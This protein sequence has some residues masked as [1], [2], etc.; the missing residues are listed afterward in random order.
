M[1][2]VE[3][4]S[5]ESQASQLIAAVLRRKETTAP[6]TFEPAVAHPVEDV[7]PLF[8][9]SSSDSSSRHSI[10][11]YHLHSLA[12]SEPQSRYGSEDQPDGEESQKENAPVSREI[13]RSD[14]SHPVAPTSTFARPPGDLAASEMR[15]PTRHRFTATNHATKEISPRIPPNIDS[16][17]GATPVKVLS[18]KS[19]VVP[20]RGMPH[21]SINVA[22]VHT[23]HSRSVPRTQEQRSPSPA[24]QDSLVIPWQDP[25]P[26]FL[27]TTEVLAI[28]SS[29]QGESSV[30]QIG[31]S[32]RTLAISVSSLHS[33]L[34]PP[35]AG[36]PDHG[37]VLVAATPSNSDSSQGIPQGQATSLSD[38]QIHDS[39]EEDHG[40]I[41]TAPPSPRDVS[42]ELSSSYRRLLDLDLF[43]PNPEPLIATQATSQFTT[44][45]TQL[46]TQAT[47]SINQPG[48]IGSLRSTDPE[49]DIPLAFSVP[50]TTTTRTAIPR[51]MLGLVHPNKLWRF[52]G[53]RESE[54]ISSTSK[55]QSVR[56]EYN[57]ETTSVN[58]PPDSQEDSQP[59]DVSAVHGS[60]ESENSERL[61]PAQS[62]QS[63]RTRQPT[64]P[65]IVPDSVATQIDIDNGGGLRAIS[66]PHSAPSLVVLTKHSSLATEN[67]GR[68]GKDAG[69]SDADDDDDV[70]LAAA[71]QS[72]RKGKERADKTPIIPR[73]LRPLPHHAASETNETLHIAVKP[74]TRA[75]TPQI[76]KTRQ[77]RRSWETE[78]IPSSHPEDDG[79]ASVAASKQV[80]RSASG[81]TEPT[82]NAR[83]DSKVPLAVNS[84]RTA[85]R[86]ESEE[87]SS[88][89]SDVSVVIPDA[90]EE[91]ATELADDDYMDI[92]RASTLVERAPS[93]KRKL[94]VSTKKT[95]SKVFTRSK[96]ADSPLTRPNKRLKSASAARISN[97]PATRVFALWRKDGL[98]YSGVVHEQRGPNRYLIKFDDNTT[99]TVDISKMRL[100][101]LKVGDHILLHD[102]SKA[103]VIEVTEFDANDN[104]T[105]ENDDGDDVETLNMQ[106]Q[107]LRIASRTLMSE[108]KDRV[109]TAASIIPVIKPKPSSTP[110]K[111]SIV[112]GSSIKDGRKKPLAKAGLVVSL[113]VGRDNWE[114]EKSR[115]ML[116]IKDQ[117]GIVIDDWSNIISMAGTHSQNNKRWV[118]VQEDLYLIKRNDIDR[119]FLVSDNANE[120]PKYLMALALGIPCVNEE[121]LTK[122][123]SEDA[124]RTWQSFL[125]PAGFCD[126]LH[127]RVSQKVE[128]DWGLSR[129]CLTEILSG[130]VPCKPFKDKSVL[131]L[132]PDFVP[133]P[134]RTLKRNCSDADKSKEASRMVP[135]I[136]MCMGAS[137]VEAVTEVRQAS[138]DLKKFDFVVVKDEVDASIF[139][140]Q[141]INCVHL[142]WVKDCVI[143]GRLLPFP[144]HH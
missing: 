117:G 120:K 111:S 47:E 121:W 9:G 114:K 56:A 64:D 104:V 24:S 102:G 143:A 46:A 26:P 22:N 82:V 135:R 80:T 144:D 142:Q 134:A 63:S 108:W 125:L 92:D 136:V 54:P 11:Q 35:A 37:Q 141:G 76:G 73:S 14:S 69:E 45:S 99:D 68:G 25:K 62:A 107:D 74:V 140:S 118:L 5:C 39:Q 41:G 106:V 59:S 137:T 123:V 2:F 16:T 53:I 138:R 28:P 94:V 77:G 97:L 7:V 96:T 100:C 48:G 90:R 30:K 70:P 55:R 60:V 23:V 91:E 36:R 109:L 27:Q 3:Q 32:F 21:A 4:S 139:T 119:L 83:P 31:P 66:S 81:A 88:E 57:I 58:P 131:C 40:Y 17:A 15:P 133:L 75:I 52:Q 44:Q 89:L 71:L 116:A 29:E 103:R 105:V 33:H 65:D 38:Y 72:K 112:S 51:R 42:T 127:T 49:H 79:I 98:Y 115:L 18:F 13:R 87:E 130:H 126:A 86:E 8:Q 78:V 50:S 1:E 124:E 132:S 128:W 61:L 20:Q 43:A 122:N 110:S 34:F 6:K 129:E 19:P 101:T 93:R 12:V 113:S 67:G 85:Q 95:A 84:S 10:P